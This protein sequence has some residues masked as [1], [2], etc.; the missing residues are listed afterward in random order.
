MQLPQQLGVV[1]VLVVACGNWMKGI[2]FVEMF[3][4]V[5]A[6]PQF[7]FT[8]DLLKPL[9][10]DASGEDAQVPA[11]SDHAS[12]YTCWLRGVGCRIR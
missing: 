4:A 12:I 8:R 6:A 1:G 7:G 5:D 9:G 10:A 3:R 2:D 11:R